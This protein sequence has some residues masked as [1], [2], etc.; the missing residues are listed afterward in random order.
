[1][2]LVPA[3]N[4]SLVDFRNRSNLNN[5]TD[6]EAFARTKKYV[7]EDGPNSTQKDLN[8]RIRH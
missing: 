2:R 8:G 4:E 7:C 3:H 5:L 1:M 6:N